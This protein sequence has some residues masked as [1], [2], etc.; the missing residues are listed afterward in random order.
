M[1][2]PTRPS[3]GGQ[4]PD[5]EFNDL[6]REYSNSSGTSS[7]SSR[8][9]LLDAGR[10]PVLSP[11]GSPRE[12]LGSVREE[13][14]CLSA[15]EDCAGQMFEPEG[16]ITG[17]VWS[18][19]GPRQ[20]AYQVSRGFQYVGD[21]NGV[22]EPEVQTTYYGWKL[23]RSCV[24]LL[25][26]VSFGLLAL[27]LLAACWLSYRE[28][29]PDSD[30]SRASVLAAAAPP[31]A[32]A[33]LLRVATVEPPRRF[34]DLPHNATAALVAFRDAC[35][36]G[37]S[38]G[39]DCNGTKSTVTSPRPTTTTAMKTMST[40]E[41]GPPFDC[42][43]LFFDWENKW[44]AQKKEW[45]CSH[46]A[47]GCEAQR[48]PRL[49]PTRQATSRQPR[50]R[51]ALAVVTTTSE[52]YDCNLDYTP[53]RSCEQHWWTI[54]KRIWCCANKGRGCPP[55]GPSTS[56]QPFDCEK[57]DPDCDGRC[58]QRRWSEEQRRWC[59]HRMGRGCPAGP[60]LVALRETLQ[61]APSPAGVE[62]ISAPGP[63]WPATGTGAVG[64]R[65][66]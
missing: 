60:P 53:C 37:A 51:Q 44:S 11:L 23:R 12:T 32:A 33:A 40:L 16:T 21:G 46:H 49:Q 38:Q 62:A 63:R 58:L 57:D 18:Y 56:S 48:R 42:E 10:S 41:S 15:A 65:G 2:C 36:E 25:L 19:V 9:P 64:N 29:Q 55:P 4:F 17:N 54:G 20:G 28:L 59:C 34:T 1:D 13:G 66:Q 39:R 30:H 43:L 8:H 35:K 26:G 50:P 45:C 31:A 3:R 61:E 6:P 24:G 22:W 27:L 5:W 7:V 14:P 52:P 47:T